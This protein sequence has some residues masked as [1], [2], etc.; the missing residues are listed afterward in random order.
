MKTADKE[1]N[2]GQNPVT[3]SKTQHTFPSEGD[4]GIYVHI[5]FC[6][7]RCRYCAFFS[8]A[9]MDAHFDSYVT[10]LLNEAHGTA[11]AIERSVNTLYIGG[12]TPT[13]LPVALLGNLLQ[14]LLGT[15]HLL[16]G[17]EITVEANP[18]TVSQRCLNRLRA[19]GANRLS[20][21]AQSF[22]DSELDMLGRIHGTEEI[23][24]SVRQARA[25]GFDNLSM[26]LIYG[27]PGQ[28]MPT[29]TDSLYRA[30]ELS[31]Q[32]LSLYA[33]T[34]EEDTPLQRDV[35]LGL[36]PEPDPDLAADMY[37]AADHILTQAGY[38]NYEISNWSLPG[39]RSRH[40]LIYWHNQAYLGVGAG[41]HSSTID[42][43]WW[44][45]EN[46]LAYIQRISGY[47]GPW[48]PSPAA[49][50]EETIDLPLQMGETMMMGLRLTA[51]GVRDDD[52]QNRFG[53][54]LDAVY[55]RVIPSLVN[56][57]LLRREE[58]KLRL[59]RKGRLLGNQVFAR[60]LP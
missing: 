48:L 5:P 55:G 3:E 7:A 56:T 10:A 45:V 57:G 34:L 28:E 40:N 2:E 9:G 33:L 54:T 19:V 39:F 11:T 44:N 43:R 26:D 37:L 49:E 13:V 46:I 22:D 32:H 35:A 36:L 47:P 42:R 60:F 50:G 58:G 52:F 15:F 20:L 16:P 18:G 31:P 59:S 8:R 51:D 25:A 41:A 6:L 24:L 4:M 12:G 27:L 1:A 14:Q 30:I 53:Q 29:W 38:E 21:G 17:A 23:N